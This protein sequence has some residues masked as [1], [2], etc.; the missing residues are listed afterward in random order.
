MGSVKRLID[1]RIVWGL[2]EFILLETK[3]YSAP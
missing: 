3:I 1:Y 2:Q